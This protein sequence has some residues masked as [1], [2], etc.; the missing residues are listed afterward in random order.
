MALTL[1]GRHGQREGQGGGQGEGEGEGGGRPVKN[2]LALPT[3]LRLSQEAEREVQRRTAAALAATAAEE[4][5]WTDKVTYQ[6]TQAFDRFTAQMRGGGSSPHQPATPPPRHLI[7]PPPHHSATPPPHD[8]TNPTAYCSAHQP[9]TP[10]PHQVV[11]M[12]RWVMVSSRR[13]GRSPPR[14]RRRRRRRRAGRAQAWGTRGRL[15]RARWSKGGV[16]RGRP[17]APPQ[18]ANPKTHEPASPPIHQSA[19]PP[20]HHPT[21]PPL[22]QP[23]TPPPRHLTNYYTAYCVEVRSL[24]RS[25]RIAAMARITITPQPSRFAGSLS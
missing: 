10:P 8:P 4:G 22:R 2:V 11:T 9:A 15:S 18:P 16:A 20:H 7:T 19:N 1:E 12:V 24:W 13:W 5:E 25:Q 21:N 6:A 3:A 23:A 17:A 14:R